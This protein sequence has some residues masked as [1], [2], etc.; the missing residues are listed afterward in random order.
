[1]HV[2]DGQSIAIG[3]IR[4]RVFHTPGHTPDSISLYTSD[5]VFTGDT[6]LIHG[7]GRADFAGGDAGEQYDAITR[8]LFSLPDETLVFPAH[9][10][11]GHTH[12]TIG[13]EKRTNPRVFGRT[14]QQNIDLMNNLGLSLPDK[15]QEVLQPNQ[16]AIEDESMRFPP[17]AELNRVRQ[18]TAQ[19]V[20]L[21]LSSAALPLLLDVRE[22]E[23]FTGEL[24]HIAGSRLIPLKE[25]PARV[26]EIEAD[27]EK[28][29]VVICR[30]GVRSTTAAAILTGLGFE[31]VSNLKGG[32]L[33]WNEQHL[34]V[35]R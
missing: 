15:I 9:D 27:K 17:L 8:K 10:Y 31:H 30:A 16:S 5:R 24:G 4:V 33:D 6:I 18:L 28:D 2:E 25:L 26:G 3:D 14:R 23:E 29:V 13:E 22:P 12:S 34:P 19:E 11:R 20:R 1:V 21:Q 35:E 32:M 7:T